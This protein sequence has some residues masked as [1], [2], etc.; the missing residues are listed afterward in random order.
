MLVVLCYHKHRAPATFPC[1]NTLLVKRGFAFLFKITLNQIQEHKRLKRP[2]SGF[3]FKWLL[4]ASSGDGQVVVVLRCD[5]GLTHI[6]K[7]STV[8]VCF[9]LSTTKGKKSNG[10]YSKAVFVLKT[11]PLVPCIYQR[12]WSMQLRHQMEALLKVYRRVRPCKREGGIGFNCF[13]DTPIGRNCWYALVKVMWDHPVRHEQCGPFCQ[14]RMF[15]GF[16]GGVLVKD[17]QGQVSAS[18]GGNLLWIFLGVK[19]CRIWPRNLWNAC[20]LQENKPSK[21]SNQGV[22]SAYVGS[23]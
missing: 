17:W 3:F 15:C 18:C 19:E 14:P 1:W 20:I 8:Q 16:S 7:I 9:L 10:R 22:A 12:C 13:P 6:L 4:L 21:Y 2:R 11:L 5:I 23:A